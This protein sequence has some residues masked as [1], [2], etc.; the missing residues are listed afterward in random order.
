MAEQPKEKDFVA[1]AR[2]WSKALDSP[3]GFVML[4]FGIAA[5]YYG[6]IDW[7]V[8]CIVR[9]PDFRA[10]V[11]KRVRPAMMFDSNGRGLSDM[12]A[13]ALLERAPEVQ[14]NT[15]GW[16]TKII[17]HPKQFLPVEPI[18]E[19]LDIGNVS[20]SV[21]R[22]RGTSW[23]VVVQGRDQLLSVESNPAALSPSRYRL[24]IVPP[25]PKNP[26]CSASRV[27]RFALY[28]LHLSTIRM[29]S[30][31]WCLWGIRIG[32]ALYSFRN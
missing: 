25:Y 7:R 23:E 2:R 26:P 13:M 8:R 11:A 30:A 27:V 29:P 20:V 31:V 17:I 28:L 3:L 4:M 14:D 5:A 16:G 24:E 32:W 6:T 18:V 15:N 9:D 10:E 12:G 19:S 1:T 21:K 22:N